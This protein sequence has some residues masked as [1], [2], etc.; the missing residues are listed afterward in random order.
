M[1]SGYVT[2]LLPV[3]LASRWADIASVVAKL[4][5]NR[6][7]PGLDESA[8][9]PASRNNQAGFSARCDFCFPF[10]VAFADGSED[11]MP[12]YCR[13]L[14]MVSPGTRR[15]RKLFL[16]PNWLPCL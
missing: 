6:L 3:T 1:E 16:A 5:P 11:T 8:G 15:L 12:N 9:A 4:L 2:A 13:E 14:C 10:P 7:D